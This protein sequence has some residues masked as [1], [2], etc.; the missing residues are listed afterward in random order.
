MGLIHLL[1]L[2]FAGCGIHGYMWKDWLPGDLEDCLLNQCKQADLSKLTMYNIEYMCLNKHMAKLNAHKDMIT[3]LT[4]SQKEYLLHL[5]RK[6][7]G[8]EYAY[9]RRKRSTRLPAHFLHKRQEIRV[10]PEKQRKA[11]FNALNKLKT[12]GFYD[13]ISNLHQQTAIQGA[14]FGCGFLGWHRVFLLILQLAVWDIN[15]TVM[16]PYCDTRLDYN[17][18]NP[19]DTILSSQ[20]YFGNFNGIV[21]SGPFKNWTT[22]TNVKLQRNGF[23][24]G[25]FITDENIRQTMAKR[26][27]REVC[28]V[29]G[30]FNIEHYHNSVH[31]IIGGLM[32]DLNWAPCDPIFFC[33]HNFIDYV[34]EQFRIHQRKDEGIDPGNDY[35]NTN[36]NWHKPDAKMEMIDR[37]L[38][39]NLTHKHGYDNMFSDE[40]MIAWEKSPSYPNCGNSPDIIKDDTRQ[41]CHS[42]SLTVD[43]KKNHTW[44]GVMRSPKKDEF[45]V[46]NAFK[47]ASHDRRLKKN[48]KKRSVSYRRRDK[49]TWNVPARSSP[50]DYTVENTFKLNDKVTAKAW[51]FIPVR[52]VY[53]R[54]PGAHFDVETA[55]YQ[56]VLEEV[57]EN[58]PQESLS[59]A[60]KDLYDPQNY[61][62][63]WKKIKEGKPASYG[64][65][66]AAGS[67]AYK[68]M[69]KSTGFSYNGKYTDY[70]IVDERQALSEAVAYVAIKR[71]VGNETVKS[72][73]MAYD[74]AGNVCEARCKVPGSKPP[75][76]ERCSG[77]IKVNSKTPK[78]YGENLG[79]AYLMRYRFQGDDL[80]SNHD[81]DIFLMFFC[82]YS[83]EC[84]WTES[85]TKKK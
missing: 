10:M 81:G 64:K 21:K 84:P 72:F 26:H 46:T 34:W 5:G 13:A 32:G 14:H 61:P 19:R 42:I 41:V 79:D 7:K 71:P 9:R 82:K 37:Y 68:I 56:R 18:N 60:D 77:V 23:N 17:M 78:M 36:D 67:G 8:I 38:N 28:A 75:K 73:V 48:I 22:P 40:I 83:N 54:R 29:P 62:R 31:V 57:A 3:P 49:K 45:K 58:K 4:D 74:P 65:I 76:Y 25:S 44:F 1:F 35:P 80:P 59:I 63:L 16:L 27:T 66:R 12:R 24:G 15:P 30:I 43:E 53:K 2:T 33:H 52:I 6:F 20:K 50:L 85:Y 70:A 51:G 69:V 11:Y 55:K 47:A 39:L